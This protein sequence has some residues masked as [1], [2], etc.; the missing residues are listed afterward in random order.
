MRP[1]FFLLIGILPVS[2]FSQTVNRNPQ[3][4]VRTDVQS[5]TNG[6][7]IIVEG[8]RTTIM[9]SDGSRTI[10]V[11]ATQVSPAN[12]SLENNS[13]AKASISSL[14]WTKEELLSYIA[15]LEAKRTHVANIPEQHKKALET[16]W[17]DFIDAMILHAKEMFSKLEEN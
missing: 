3:N 4:S 17:Y 15:S 11:D 14:H 13:Q 7:V 16:G 8:N 10:T 6:D 2:L 12:Y 1:I 9:H 5:K